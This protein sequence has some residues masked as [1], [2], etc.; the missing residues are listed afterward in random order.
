MDQFFQKKS[1]I[2]RSHFL[3]IEAIY[4]IFSSHHR[5]VIHFNFAGS[6]SGGSKMSFVLQPVVVSEELLKPT[7]YFVFL[8]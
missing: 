3:S 8:A 7:S 2:R 1:F 6:V 5:K 4:Y